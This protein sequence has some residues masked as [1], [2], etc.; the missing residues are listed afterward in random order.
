MSNERSNRESQ[1][2]DAIDRLIETGR[3]LEEALER[4]RFE[5]E[6]LRSTIGTLREEAEKKDPPKP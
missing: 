4:E 5:N 3:K 1:L 2:E 6:T